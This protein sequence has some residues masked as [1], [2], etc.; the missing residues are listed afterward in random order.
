MSTAPA[1]HSVDIK[2]QKKDRHSNTGVSGSPKKGGAGGKGTWGV[3]GLDDL[4]IDPIDRDDPNYDSED[5]QA[6]GTVLASAIIRNEDKDA[7][8]VETTLKEYFTSGDVA[9]VV[10]SV[11]EIRE[12]KR[13]HFVK[14][15]LVTAMDYEAAQREQ[16]SKLLLKLGG[17]I[18]PNDF[19]LGFQMAIDS[20]EDISLD[21]P[22][23]PELLSKFIARAVFDE[24][25][26]PKFLNHAKTGT[27][28]ADLCV[29][30]ANAF[31]NE[32][33]RADKLAHVWGITEE[34]SI[35][36]LRN[37]ARLIFEEYLVSRDM[38]EATASLRNLRAPDFNFQVV[39]E[40]L[41][42]ALEKE[43]EQRDIVLQL[44]KNFSTSNLISASH[45]AHGFENC[46]KTMDDLTLDLPKAPTVLPT[47]VE[48]AKTE[49]WLDKE[50]SFTP[51]PKSS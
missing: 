33:F 17:V 24:V 6:E 50:F 28:E 16:A 49:G 7:S 26:P 3:G 10:A 29:R 14:K 18:S 1:S 5:D 34:S 47:L 20:L 25:I 43:G 32:R 9:D 11:K 30:L 22:N 39:R 46:F 45:F 41:K 40:G 19:S 2:N 44:L 27:K 48:R 15:T 31:S 38:K 37:E 21:V 42:V 35:K 8:K 13:P 51:A 36:R 12:S 23:A 4:K